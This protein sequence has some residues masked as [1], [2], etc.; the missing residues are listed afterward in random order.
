M[1]GGLRLSYQDRAVMDVNTNRLQALF[2]YLA[3]HAGTLQSRERLAFLFWPDST[4]AQA[5]TNLRQLLHHLR[6]A[7]PD[8]GEFIT[9]DSQ[10]ILWLSTA[11]FAIDVSNFENAIDRAQEAARRGDSVTTRKELESAAQFY[12][13]DFMPGL[14]DEWIEIER[15][16]FRQK[17]SDVLGQLISLLERTREF[18]SAIQYAERLLSLDPCCE[19]SYQTLMRLHGLRSSSVWILIQP[20]TIALFRGLEVIGRRSI[21]TRQEGRIS[22]S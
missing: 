17:I 22:I 15:Q 1:L 6:S 14:Y 7:L 16:R 9:A 21:L 12:G 10:N 19:T 13:G 3:L 20:I 18:S 11:E 2:A 4:E 5:R 8:G